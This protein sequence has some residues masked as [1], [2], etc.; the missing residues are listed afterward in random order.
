MNIYLTKY[1]TDRVL[2]SGK[3]EPSQGAFSKPKIFG[4]IFSKLIGINE[5]R[6]G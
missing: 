1:G 4:I 6:M 5:R 3:I 2:G